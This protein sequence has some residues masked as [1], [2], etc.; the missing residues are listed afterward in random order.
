[1]RKGCIAGIVTYN[2]EMDRL[3]SNIL[4]IVK[5]ADKVIVIDNDS[6][7]KSE[8]IRLLKDINN[9]SI[10]FISN[11]ANMGI[12]YA[13]NQIGDAAVEERSDFFMTLDQDSIADED[14]LDKMLLLFDDPKVGGVAPDLNLSPVSKSNN[15]ELVQGAI[16]SGFVVRTELWKEIGGFWDFLFIDEVD[17]EFSF[18]IRRK[19]YKILR[20][21]DVSINHI[22][23]ESFEKIVFHHKF[24]PTNH[25]AFR[26]YYIARNNIIMEYLYPETDEL[27]AH[28]E[29]MLM[30]TIISIII[31]EEDKLERIH[32]IIKGIRDGKK[33]CSQNDCILERRIR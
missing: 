15:I 24:H 9:E 28:R 22:I 30:R 1:M 3:K 11:D 18:Q 8:I 2:P 12:A 17:Y 21:H 29:I 10:R 20:R 25:S 4:S 32:A 19:G 7:N 14:M 16:S 13:M 23:G 6:L 33:W 27:Y 31:C 26:R 5:Q